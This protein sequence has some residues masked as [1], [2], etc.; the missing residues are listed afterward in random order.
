MKGTITKARS[1]PIYIWFRTRKQLLA[2]SAVL[3]FFLTIGIIFLPIARFLLMMERI[4]P[5]TENVRV[6]GD[7]PLYPTTKATCFLLHYSEPKRDSIIR[8]Y[9]L[10]AVSRSNYLSDSSAEEKLYLLLRVLF[11]VPEAQPRESARVFA[12]WLGEGSPY[13]NDGS[14]TVNLLWPLE[15]HDEQ[16]VLRKL[17]FI[18]YIGPPYNG[19]AEYNFF[20][21][22]FPFRTVEDLKCE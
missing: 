15:Y 8:L 4:E 10:F 19:L 17:S 7:Y 12:P 14:D 20:V 11:N 6:G 5:W 1:N 22:S 18:T 9:Y 13:P 21:F 2:L 3:M 16:L